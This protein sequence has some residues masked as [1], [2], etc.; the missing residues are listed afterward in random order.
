MLHHVTLGGKRGIGQHLA[1]EALR[2]WHF[3]AGNKGARGFLAWRVLG[4]V[5][6]QL[7]SPG[8]EATRKLFSHSL[9]AHWR[10]LL[11]TPCDC[12]R[13]LQPPPRP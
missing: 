2:P 1:A 8:V 6:F 11:E 7:P 12:R 4:P 10:V 9:R 5:C 13:P 3:L